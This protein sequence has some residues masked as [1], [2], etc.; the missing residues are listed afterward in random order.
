M[1]FTGSLEGEWSRQLIDLMEFLFR[2]DGEKGQFYD[3]PFHI[4]EI[5]LDEVELDFLRMIC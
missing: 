4:D 1:G 5:R 3:F 2:K